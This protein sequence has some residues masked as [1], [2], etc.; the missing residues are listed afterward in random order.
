MSKICDKNED[1]LI[2]I[3]HGISWL[4]PIHLKLLLL[5]NLLSIQKLNEYLSSNIKTYVISYPKC[6]RT[7]LRMLIGK[8]FQLHYDLRDIALETLLEV[9]KLPKLNPKIPRVVFVHDDQPQFKTPDELN[10]DKRKYRKAKV[11]FLVRDP[12]D[13]VVSCYFEFTKRSSRALFSYNPTFQGTMTEFIRYRSGSISTIIKYF[14]IWAENRRLPLKFLLLRYEDLH[15]N[16]YRELLKILKFIGLNNIKPEHIYKAVK[17]AQFVN[18]R[19]LESSGIIKLPWLLPGKK[20][21]LE[22][23]KTRK[24]VVGGYKTYL[25]KDDIQYI[26]TL[27]RRFL[28]NYFYSY[29]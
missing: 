1:V 21:D 20:N 4:T 25:K 27:L 18:M 10:T 8:A 3:L 12:R 13:V 24:G 17:F 29:K 7:W 19:K 23:Y 26:N 22:S 11:I 16:A 9:E 28:H 14:N 15:I 6:G 5:K 2:K